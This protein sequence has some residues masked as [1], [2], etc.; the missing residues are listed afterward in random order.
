MAKVTVPVGRSVLIGKNIRV[1]ISELTER[2]HD[3]DVHIGTDA[4]RN[5]PVDRKEVRERQLREGPRRKR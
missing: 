2:A 1:E 5:I 4:P 3:Y